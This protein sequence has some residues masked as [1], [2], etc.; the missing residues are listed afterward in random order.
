VLECPVGAG[1]GNDAPRGGV[2]VKGER[3]KGAAGI[4][5]RAR[6]P[7]VGGG[8]GGD[9][10]QEVSLRA[11]ARPS[12]DAPLLAIPML[13]EGLL[14]PTGIER[15]PHRPDIVGGDGGHHLESGTRPGG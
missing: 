3:Q 1:R 5:E 7:D 2:P 14:A 9:S 6:G 12:N 15:S 13:D 10:K 11:G 4:S 8:D